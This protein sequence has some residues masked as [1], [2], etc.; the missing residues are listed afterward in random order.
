M[1][2][3]VSELPWTGERYVPQL[4]GNIAL[5]HLHRYALASEFVK[6]KRVLDIASGEGYGSEMLSRAAA[7]VVGVDLD[8]G[9]VEHAQKK[10]GKENLSFK[11]GNCEQIPLSDHSVDV[12]VSFE[13]IEHLTNHEKMLSE[14]KR[15]LTPD[16]ILIVSTP[17]KHEYTEVPKHHNQFHVK[18]LYRNEFEKLLG[19]Y[20]KNQKFLGQRIA[21]GSNIL[22][23]EEPSDFGGVYEFNSLLTEGE[24]TKRLFQ[25]LYLIAFCSDVK[26]PSIDSTLCEQAFYETEAYQ[27]VSQQLSEKETLLKKQGEVLLKT[28]KDLQKKENLLAEGE[29]LINRKN[30][31]IREQEELIEQQKALISEKENEIQDQKTIVHE[32]DLLLAE[33][34]RQLPNKDQ[35]LADQKNIS[36]FI[37]RI[38]RALEYRVMACRIGRS[39]SFDRQWYLEQHPAAAANMDSLF[40]YVC[41][42]EKE[43]RQ[44][45]PLFDS[46]N[47]DGRK[48]KAHLPRE[49]SLVLLPLINNINKKYGPKVSLELDKIS[50]LLFAALTKEE[51]QVNNALGMLQQQIKNSLF[52]PATESYFVSIIIPVHNQ[53]AYT[54]ACVATILNSEIKGN[55]E[56]LIAD[57]ASTDATATIFEGLHPS[58]KL[59]HQSSNLGFLGNC[60]EAAKQAQGDY[61]LFLNNDTLV[62]PGWINALVDI[63]KTHPDAGLVGAKLLNTDGTLQEAGG[64]IWKDASGCNYGRGSNPNDYEY[65]YVKEV[66]YCSGA[67]LMIALKLWESLGGFDE[68][69]SPAYYEDT[70]LAFRVRAHGKKVMYQ[71]KA[72]VI[73]LEGVSHGKDVSTGIKA[74]Q[75]VNQK[76]FLAR[77]KSGLNQYHFSPGKHFFLAR[78]RLPKHKTILF[79]DHAIP[80]PDRDAGSKSVV[81]HMKF[82]MRQGFHVVLIGDNGHENPSYEELLQQMGVE[83]LP[84][85]NFNITQQWLAKN[86]RYIDYVF[87]SR[88]H[89]SLRWVTPL[90]KKTKAKILFYGHDL[91]SRTRERAFKDTRILSHKLIAQEFKRHEKAIHP[92]VDVIYYP[93]QVEVDALSNELK[94]KEVRKIPLYI[95]ED[96]FKKNNYDA[97]SRNGLL[98]VGGFQHPPNLD[99][100]LYFINNIFPKVLKLL[101]QLQLTIVGADAPA[102]LLHLSSENVTI[103]SNISDEHLLELMNYSKLSIVPLRYGGGIKGKIIDAMKNGL[104]VLTT[105]IGAEGLESE[106]GH[107]V[108]SSL[109]EFAGRLVEIYNNNEDLNVI[110][111]T[112]QKYVAD[113]FSEEAMKKALKDYVLEIK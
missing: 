79:I 43:G 102:K 31:L 55:F 11:K 49:G 20:F 77:W 41:F 3:T 82:F 58:I 40:H 62:L 34:G 80:T 2:E 27:S 39:K 71:S 99:A 10:Y 74:V 100:V 29:N 44:P 46:H 106:K 33:Q 87:L 75:V 51:V 8:P 110:S 15:V 89:T 60:N 18:E 32:K 24:K 81:S 5:E 28:N 70:D 12:V 69:Y 73:H 53:L 59:I 112:G 9:A 104:P 65:N 86:G 7:S 42:G 37:K 85:K 78:C 76:K 48:N 91:I 97:A 25:P 93:S 72:E 105:P 57:D 54:L 101:P 47:I 35:E 45:R 6:G 84:N 13:T 4:R 90:R 95:F 36:S 17:D 38:K 63:F 23:I 22:S 111:R 50:K 96:D 21:Y 16:G 107:I 64:I 88:P 67:C 92:L 56:I 103:K 109:D 30:N 98:F 52:P 68:Q 83:I 113:N 26:L 14:V 19:T 94:E 108:V 66:D 61:I 1:D